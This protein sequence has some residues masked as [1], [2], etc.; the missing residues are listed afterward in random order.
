MANDLSGLHL[1]FYDLIFDEHSA[2]SEDLNPVELEVVQELIV[3]IDD[4]ASLVD[5]LMPFPNVITEIERVV[6]AD[7]YSAQKLSM[8]IEQ[9]PQE[10]ALL[11]KLANSSLYNPSQRPI[12]SIPQ[13]IALIGLDKIHELIVTAALQK[14]STCP[15]IY[16]KMFGEN[17]WVH[18]YQSALI[19]Q[20]LAKN[21]DYED[22]EGAYL[23]GLVHDFGKVLIFNVL[24]KVIRQSHPDVQPGSLLFRKMLIEYSLIMSSNIAKQWKLPSSLQKA[25]FE[26]ITP[27]NTTMSELGQLVHKA[28]T[29]SEIYMLTKAGKLNDTQRQSLLENSLGLCEDIYT[30]IFTILDSI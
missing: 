17:V 13:A 19:A 2:R 27:E 29:L 14:A 22:I 7:D 23:A 12:S 25:L 8:V 20:Q 6:K 15:K 10:A 3:A 28:N 5:D 4:P 18:S 26:V 24:I 1:K 9:A 30:E 16:F 21:I 11:L